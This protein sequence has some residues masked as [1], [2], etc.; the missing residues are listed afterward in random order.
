MAR[1]LALCVL[2]AAVA[3]AA[4]SDSDDAP[5][6]EPPKS[7]DGSHFFEPFLSKY[8]AFEPSK[9]PDFAGEWAHE[10]HKHDGLPG[11]MGL[12]VSSPAKKHAVSTLFAEP[13]DPKASGGLVIQYELQLKNRLQCGGAYLKLLS[14]SNELSHDGFKAETPY[15][16]MFGPD[17][18]G[19]TNKVHFILRHRNPLSGEWEEKHLVGPP[20]PEVGD[21]MTHLYTAIV[22]SDNSVKLLVDNKQVKTA[23][24]LSKNDFKPA[25]NP[26]K[27][28]DDPADSKPEDWVDEAKMDDPA[29][30]KPEDWD[31]DA[32]PRIV[33]PAAEK[34][35][36]WLDDAPHK[37]P[38]PKAT[39][40]SDWDVDE[41]GEW[42][43]PMVDNPD[44]S[45]AGKGCG[46]W[47]A[48]EIANPEYKGKWHAA[49]IDNPAYI[50]V[51]KPR[52]VDNPHYF[53]DDTPYAMAPIGG[54]GIELWTMQEGILFD[55]IVLSGSPEVAASIAGSAFEPRAA[56]EKASKKEETKKGGGT[57]AK[58]K[59]YLGKAFDWCF[60]NAMLV[61][62]TL[63]MGVLPLLLFCCFGSKKKEPP[64]AAAEP[65]S[66]SGGKKK[67][68][69]ASEPG[70]SSASATDA[71]EMPEKAV[72]KKGG[73]KKRTPKTE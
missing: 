37:V 4:D 19:S 71:D 72:G 29:A 49:K 58:V 42:E 47:K 32:P 31:E 40:P 57:M 33:D 14:A 44:C 50:G 45:G 20:S 9:D 26:E 66:S 18:C 25:I 36:L 27:I 68:T 46:E 34:P 10:T 60:E 67:A 12:V 13:F 5:V 63:C 15:T 43:A 38:D 28:I 69:A 7:L 3:L 56:A 35:A 22:G 53:E 70:P 11:D 62:A 8:G 17:H 54:I 21:G 52:Q 24:L 64:A 6:Y 51:W 16:V 2:F 55:N 73:G 65:S 39:P 61:G 23:S 30:K 48:P 59:S 41:D 1:L